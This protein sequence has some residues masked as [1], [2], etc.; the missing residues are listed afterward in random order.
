MNSL[1]ICQLQKI[2][3]IRSNRVIYATFRDGVIL[4]GSDVTDNS[5]NYGSESLPI[6]PAREDPETRED[7]SERRG[8]TTTN[9]IDKSVVT[10]ILHLVCT[11]LVHIS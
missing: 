1:I 8:N 9:T 6:I 3:A 11:N 7:E 4:A 5:Y 10:N 2:L